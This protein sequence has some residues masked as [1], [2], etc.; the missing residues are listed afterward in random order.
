MCK[1]MAREKCEEYGLLSPCHQFSNRGGCWFC[2]NAKLEEHREIKKLY[3]DV[4]KQFVSLENEDN[5]ANYKYNVYGKTLH[6]ID[7]ELERNGV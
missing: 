1:Q 5:V 2:P 3:P 4:W 7:E 6:E